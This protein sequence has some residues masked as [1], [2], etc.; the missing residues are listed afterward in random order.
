MLRKESLVERKIA[1]PQ[2]D[3]CARKTFEWILKVSTCVPP[4][5][6]V[7]FAS[8]QNDILSGVKQFKNTLMFLDFALFIVAHI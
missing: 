4:V 6:E 1:S 5:L 3:I 2:V 8:N 7:P